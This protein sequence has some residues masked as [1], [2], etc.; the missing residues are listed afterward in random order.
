M[1]ED[2]KTNFQHLQYVENIVRDVHQL[3]GGQPTFAKLVQLLSSPP[4]ER[5]KPKAS[6]GFDESKIPDRRLAW[7]EPSPKLSPT[8]YEVYIR[9]ILTP[10]ERLII[11]AHE[12]GHVILGQVINFFPKGPEKACDIFAEKL[13]GKKEG[14]LDKIRLKYKAI[15]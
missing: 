8:F 9:N 4:S 2:E 12:M 7:N 1:G 11:L 14:T 6:V 15:S 5:W 3:C 13:L 10:D